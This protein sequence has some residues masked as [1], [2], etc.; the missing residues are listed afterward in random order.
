MKK[1]FLCLMLIFTTSLCI[2]SCGDKNNQDMPS[3]IVQFVDEAANG[4]ENEN[5]LN[6]S[7]DV[8]GADG[9]LEV[10]DS[11]DT[12]NQIEEILSQMTLEEKVGQMFITRPENQASI[13]V[14]GIC[15]FS[16]NIET[17]E[18]L[19]TLIE[20]QN[21]S[22]RTAPFISVDEEGGRVSRIANSGLYK[23]PKYTSML[24]VGSEEDAE[25][26]K[27]VGRNIG[28]YLADLGFNL[29]FAPVADVNTNPDNPVIGERAFSN[30]PRIVASMVSSFMDG[31]HEENVMTTIK[32]FPGHGDTN[33]DSHTG[34]V[35]TDKT[36]DELKSCELIPYYDNLLKTDMVMAA[37]INTP[38]ITMDERPASLSKEMIDGKLRGELGYDGV[39]ITDSLEMGAI[40]DTYSPIQVGI[41]A[42]NAGIDILLLPVQPAETYNAI[43]DAV[44][45][46]EI[47]EERI[48]ESV[49]RILKLKIKYGVIDEWP[50]EISEEEFAVGAA[51]TD[52]YLPLLKDKKV[53]ILS[54][55]TGMVGDKHT[56]DILVEN[57]VN[58]TTIF[59][60]EHGFRG[61]ASAGEKV[62]ASVD[63]ITGIPIKSL[64][65]GGKV[66]SSD[67][68][69]IDVIVCDI[70]DVGVRFYTYYITMMDMMQKAVEYDKEFIVLDRPNPNGYLVDGPVLDM[71]YKSGVGRIPVAASHGLTMGE[72]ALMI[73]GEGWLSGGQ[74]CDLNVIPCSGYT[75]DMKYDLPVAPSPN[76]PNAHAVALYPSLCGFEGTSVSV[77][78]GTEAPFEIYGHPSMS[79]D[80]SFT[81]KSCAAAKNPPQQDKMC[82][83]V[84][85]RYL[86]YDEIHA[87]GFTLEYI[88]DAYE[89]LGRPSDFFGNGEFFDKLMGN[90]WVR[91]M[92]LEG[93]SAEEIKSEWQDELGEYKKLREKYLI[94]N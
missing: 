27:I 72:I 45:T 51:R 58:V 85:L 61:T 90:S 35:K 41:Y 78:R 31:M 84:D 74:V 28:A 69:N 82:Y 44:R 50:N 36:W 4:L 70:Q 43:L 22:T 65:G 9:T 80:F 67:M 57:G 56:L 47:P 89:K 55:Q 75:H 10:S 14:G 3:G 81:P 91:T 46:D 73:N 88:V 83:G 15:I 60:P 37:H 39:V 5:E 24:D 38:N 12:D 6:N 86:S 53:A 49:R 63:S 62:S 33:A 68:D 21:S 34:F 20:K 25:G 18:D 29:D 11:D 8:S 19:K 40:T 52:E 2:V 79:E 16:Q 13:P 93:Y 66:S 71:N 26:A 87:K 32:H 17:A 54:N 1:R 23:V 77:G 59:S 64:Y 7:P 42:V 94:Y 48:N 76:L 92:V 30:D